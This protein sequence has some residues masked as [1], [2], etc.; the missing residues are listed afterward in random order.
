MAEFGFKRTE[1]CSSSWCILMDVSTTAVFMEHYR[2]LQ[3]P[4]SC[5]SCTLIH[6]PNKHTEFMYI[7]I[8]LRLHIHSNS[9]VKKLVFWTSWLLS[10]TTLHIMETVYEASNVCITALLFGENCRHMNITQFIYVNMYIAYS[11]WSEQEASSPLYFNISLK[12]AIRKVQGNQNKLNGTCQILVHADIIYWTTKCKL[13]I[14][15]TSY[16]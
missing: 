13:H 10:H 2:F 1:L 14:P 6:S 12:Y 9:K 15:K 7:F 5:N 11:K 3:T 4:Q 16:L 8:I